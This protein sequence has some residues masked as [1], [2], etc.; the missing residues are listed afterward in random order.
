MYILRQQATLMDRPAKQAVRPLVDLMKQWS[1]RA[2]QALPS[3]ISSVMSGVLDRYQERSLTEADLDSSTVEAY[4]A[5]VVLSL[6]LKRSTW[7][8]WNVL[9]EAAR[10]T[11]LIRMRDTEDRLRVLYKIAASAERQS[12][13]LTAPAP[14]RAPIHR[15]D[16]ESVFAIHNGQVYTSPAILG[17]E[18]VLLDLAASLDAP[19]LASPEPSQALG[20]DKAAVLRRVATSGQRVEAVVGPAGT[21]KTTL[22]AELKK[23]WS[24]EFGDGSVIALAP[25]AA[26]AI[27]LA[28]NLDLP[29]DNVAKWIH[30]A[31]G[32]GA[33]QRRNWIAENESA[34]QLA[35]GAGRRRRAQRLYAA[36]AAAR[37]EQ[38]RW[39]LRSNQL[40]IVDEASMV[41]TM[42]LASLAREAQKAGAKLVLVGDDSQLGA[43]DTG[44]A[45]RLLVNETK[46]AELTEVWRFHN[47]WERNASLALRSG[48]REVLDVYDDH[49]RL[50]HG[51][52]DDAENA[53]YTAWHTDLAQ[54]HTSLLIAGDNATVTRLNARA[55]LDRIQTGE[56]EPDGVELHDSTQAGLGDSVITRLNARR[57]MTDRRTFV[58]N[59]ATWTVIRRWDDGSLT[60]QNDN[61]ETVTLPADYVSESVELAYATTAH[62]AQ[63]QTVDTAHLIVTDHLTRALLYVGM[64]RGRRSNRAYVVTHEADQDMHE[65]TT[66]QTMQDILE[67]VLEQEGVERSAHEVM[68]T[69]LDNATRL[70]RLIPM[71]E[72]LCQIA[73]GQRCQAAL[74]SSALDPVDQAA[75]KAS[76]AY[77]PL[78]AALRRA[79]AVGLDGEATLHR[80]V[81]QS[82]LNNAVDLAAVLHSRVER[83]VNRAERRCRTH[84]DLIAGLVTPATNITDPQFAAPLRELESLISQRADWLAEKAAEENPTWYHALRLS[85]IE[86]TSLRHVAAYRE[87]YQ[88]H[89]NDVLGPNPPTTAHEQLRHR[90]NLSQSLEW[91]RANAG[92]TVGEPAVV[93]VELHDNEV[94]DLDPDR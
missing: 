42:E 23:A 53:A 45:F 55:R 66:E 19:T 34:A 9:A 65:P 91:R 20:Q 87:R 69:E 25:S 94:C 30:E 70:D 6:Q 8:R 17:A 27:V 12:I 33:E 78:L 72:Y 31:V 38:D 52:S 80:A 89:S 50:V 56:V 37:T 36:A 61:D 86:P 16:G 58:R 35:L 28:D 26:A 77:G 2:E 85:E 62:R 57:L 64:T 40:V 93:A 60:V 41:G 24:S 14:V 32:I 92:V 1:M 81:N 73:T 71:H 43:I 74:E 39:R 75:V 48:S 7:T 46:A 83:L 13:S 51:A 49:D 90:A 11:R 59:G 4:G 82:S 54:G 22:L 21:G 67:T 10:Q 79:E 84:P 88:I 18:A 29:A 44:G 47:T 68:R 15:L 76:T 63:G 3:Q 5:A